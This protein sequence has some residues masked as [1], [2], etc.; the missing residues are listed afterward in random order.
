V[1]AVK[2]SVKLSI[3]L[4]FGALA[5]DFLT[6]YKESGG[7][8]RPHI[9]G[10]SVAKSNR[11]LAA[12]KLQNAE[13]GRKWRSFCEKIINFAGE[14]LSIRNPQAAKSRRQA[15]PVEGMKLK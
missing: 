2:T 8:R 14:M 6:K 11:F 13:K 15:A 3:F 4:G 10:V 7:A 1:V 5:A 9:Y 12:G